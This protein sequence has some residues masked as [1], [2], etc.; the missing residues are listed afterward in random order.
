MKKNRELQKQTE[1]KK[2]Y[3][4]KYKLTTLNVYGLNAPIKRYRVG[5]LDKNIRP[6]DTLFTKDSLHN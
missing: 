6:I 5:W 4:G 2:Q 3:G 1:D